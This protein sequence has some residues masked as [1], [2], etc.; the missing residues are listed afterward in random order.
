MVFSS[1]WRGRGGKG[2]EVKTDVQVHTEKDTRILR[3]V[4][5]RRGVR[6]VY[7]PG[8]RFFWLIFFLSPFPLFS[9]PDITPFSFLS[10]MA[11]LVSS[12]YPFGR[13]LLHL[14]LV[15]GQLIAT[16]PDSGGFS[17]FT[18]F[19]F[20]SMLQ[21]SVAFASCIALFSSS[22]FIFNFINFYRQR[23]P[24]KQGLLYGNVAFTHFIA[25]GSSFP[26]LALSFFVMCGMDVR[27]ITPQRRC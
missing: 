8:A 11:R 5:G 21:A 3:Y 19:L 14:G 7:T 16:L 17:F 25:A 23:L 1:L 20:V 15:L 13:S 24:R 6:R 10:R 12:S 22:F 18:C 27:P 26:F 9:F 4:V 2:T